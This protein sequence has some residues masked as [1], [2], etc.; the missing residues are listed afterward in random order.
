M[1][2]VDVDGLSLTVG[3]SIG[4]CHSTESTDATSMMQSADVAMYRAKRQGSNIAVYGP[5]DA[6]DRLLL[7][8]Q[9]V[10]AH[11]T[12][13]RPETREAFLRVAIHREDPAAVARDLGMTPNAV[14]LIKSRILRQLRE[15][16][17][18]LLD[19]D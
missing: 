10:E 12:S 7:L 8:H 4:I 11:L 17:A 9:A 18:E 6:E 14:Y 5:E 1:E 2:P 3:V 19:L 13:N 16:F 15:E